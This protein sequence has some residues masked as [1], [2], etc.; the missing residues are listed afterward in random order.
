MIETALFILGHMGAGLFYVAH[1]H[2]AL[3]IAA[4]V[5]AFLLTLKF[6]P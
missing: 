4:C 3:T 1:Y 6:A 5:V 2:P